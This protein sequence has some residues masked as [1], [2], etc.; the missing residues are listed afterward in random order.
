MRLNPEALL[1]ISGQAMH[2]AGPDDGMALEL[3]RQSFQEVA[4]LQWMDR[5]GGPPQRRGIR[6]RLG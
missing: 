3:N 6:H 2:E 5:R 1:Q 4:P